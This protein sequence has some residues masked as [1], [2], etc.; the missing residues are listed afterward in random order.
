MQ[1]DR[2]GL[3]QQGE[4]TRRQEVPGAR[5]ADPE[6]ERRQAEPLAQNCR[7]WLFDEAPER[8][9]GADEGDERPGKVDSRSA[10][11]A[12]AEFRHAMQLVVEPAGAIQILVKMIHFGGAG[13]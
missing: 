6:I 13:C 4:I 8:L 2:L 3:V 7:E 5:A 12:V 10:I 9:G 1:D 11:N